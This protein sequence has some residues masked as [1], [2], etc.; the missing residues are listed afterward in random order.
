MKTT[1]K[2][3]CIWCFIGLLTSCTPTPVNNDTLVKKA[4][5]V[6]ATGGEHSTEPDNEKD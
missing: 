6:F 4:K 1:L 3:L 5:P 2:H